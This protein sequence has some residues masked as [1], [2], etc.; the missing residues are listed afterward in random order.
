MDRRIQEIQLHFDRRIHFVSCD[1]DQSANADLC[2]RFGVA[3]VP[4]LGVFVGTQQRRGIMG[5]RSSDA[6]IVELE[7][8]LSVSNSGKKWWQFWRPKF[9]W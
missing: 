4:F 7:A 3:N 9:S 1:I 8:R 2:K 5:L 6:L